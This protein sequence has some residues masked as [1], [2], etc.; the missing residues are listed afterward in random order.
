MNPGNENSTRQQIRVATSGGLAIPV[1]G[2]GPVPTK[3]FGSGWMTND[4]LSFWTPIK[5]FGSGRVPHVRPSEH[6]HPSRQE[7]FM[8]SQGDR[9]AGHLAIFTTHLRQA[10]TFFPMHLPGSA[11]QWKP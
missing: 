4:S 8:L 11:R 10:T 2:S 1:L 5:V 7:G 3:V 6:V 9:S